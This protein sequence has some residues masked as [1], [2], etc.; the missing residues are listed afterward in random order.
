MWQKI[1]YCATNNNLHQGCT[2]AAPTGPWRLTQCCSWATSK[3]SF[4]SLSHMLA[5]QISQVQSTRLPLILLGA[6]P[7]KCLFFVFQQI[8]IFERL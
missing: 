1:V 3:S 2:L 7:C 6:Q 8:L 5:P 4:F